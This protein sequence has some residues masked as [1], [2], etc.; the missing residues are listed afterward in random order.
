MTNTYTGMDT[1]EYITSATIVKRR[2]R[3]SCQ[4][5][6]TYIAIK[7]ANPNTVDYKHTISNDNRIDLN[8]N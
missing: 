6:G 1:S 8:Q 5:T 3:V 2:D 4:N 7:M